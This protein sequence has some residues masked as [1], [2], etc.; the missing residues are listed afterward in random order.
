MSEIDK[1]IVELI[2]DTCKFRFSKEEEYCVHAISCKIK[3]KERVNCA[4]CSEERSAKYFKKH[5]LLHQGKVFLYFPIHLA[6]K[7]NDESNE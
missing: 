6:S 5:I 2:C 3:G 7:E 1:D 4:I